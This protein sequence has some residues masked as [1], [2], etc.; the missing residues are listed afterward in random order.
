[1]NQYPVT[2]TGDE[3]DLA[4]NEMPVQPNSQPNDQPNSQ[5]NDQSNDL[6][7]WTNDRIATCLEEVADELQA[8]GANPYRTTAYRRGAISVRN[9]PRSMNDLLHQEGVEGLMD[10]PEIGSSLAGAIEHLLET[11]RLPLLERL[12]GRH[13]A[14]TIFATVS[15]IGPGLAKRIHEH[16]GIENL[17]ELQA[18][19]NDGRLA[20]VPGMGVKRVR[21]VRE[22]LAGRF[23]QRNPAGQRR[24]QAD[25][26][27]GDETDDDVSVPQL[28]DIDEEYRR[29]AERG[30]LPRV[31]P[32]RFNSTA[33]AWLP[34]LHTQRGEQH[35]TAMFSNTARAHQLGTTHDWVVIYRDDQHGHGR[36]TVITSLYGRTRGKRIVCGRERENDSPE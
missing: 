32:R 25:N 26:R 6:V 1:M 7:P 36:W 23:A 11:G 35:F 8:Q 5:P 9:W 3:K 28:L 29:R 14:E 12:R 15:D 21:A 20:T 33:D 10:L 13:A 34:I 18:A 17:A 2:A 30:D 31:A 16:L 22:S 4:V 19:A 24:S 27:F